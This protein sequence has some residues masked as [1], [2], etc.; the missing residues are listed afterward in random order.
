ATAGGV[1][2]AEG[3]EEGR[4]VLDA[5]LREAEGGVG[6]LRGGVGH[7]AVRAALDDGDVHSDEGGPGA[8]GESCGGAV[9]PGHHVAAGGGLPRATGP[10]VAAA[11]VRLVDFR[12][13]GGRRGAGAGRADDRPGRDDVL[14][15]VQAVVGDVVVRDGG[16]AGRDVDG[17]QGEGV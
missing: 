14:G 6:G 10:D 15:G 16:G 13:D 4:G 9:A 7:D 2:D 11:R 17:R 1:R 8:T 3:P 12:T 5:V